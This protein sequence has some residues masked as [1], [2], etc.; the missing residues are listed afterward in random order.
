MIKLKSEKAARQVPYELRGLR[1]RQLGKPVFLWSKALAAVKSAIK[2]ADSDSIRCKVDEKIAPLYFIRINSK[3][4]TTVL[5]IVL[6]FCSLK[7]L[8]DKV[9]FY[10]ETSKANI[11]TIVQELIENLIEWH[12]IKLPWVTHRGNLEDG[13]AS[14]EQLIE[15][16]KGEAGA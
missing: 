10:K 1:G 14:V 9:E 7:P 5:L 16:D 3:L 4:V 15:L 12:L 2:I 13:A 6:F 11:E 8:R